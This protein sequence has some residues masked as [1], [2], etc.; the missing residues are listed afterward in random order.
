MK[1]FFLG[2]SGIVFVL[3]AILHFVRFA[4]QW[5]V[6]IGPYSI[7]V[8]ASLWAGFVALALALGCFFSVCK[9][10]KKG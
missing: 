6:V 8:D 4:S 9:S 7:P 3:V 10:C 1:N 2:L 5:A